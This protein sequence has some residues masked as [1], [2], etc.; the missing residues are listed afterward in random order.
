MEKEYTFKHGEL[1]SI[2]QELSKLPYG[3]VA[4]IINFIDQIASK[5]E[6]SKVEGQINNGLVDSQ[7]E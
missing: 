2:I 1:V 4:K 5:D 3:Q 7:S 6:G